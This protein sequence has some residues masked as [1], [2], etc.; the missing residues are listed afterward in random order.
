MPGGEQR[1]HNRS[2]R[3]ASRGSRGADRGSRGQTL[4]DYTLGISLFIVTLAAVLT[5][6][7]G[8]TSP[9][10]AGV[11]A[12]DVSQSDRITTALVQNHSTGRTPTELDAEGLNG[13]LNQSLSELRS[14]WGIEQT[15]NLNVTVATLNGTLIVEYDGVKLAAGVGHQEQST[16]TTSRVVT[17]DAGTCDPACRLVVRTW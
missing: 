12:E 4:Q 9:L 6:L 8:F 2:F 17:L 7:V 10:S 15:T 1:P 13:T 14:R 3:D 11:S 16:G 5:G